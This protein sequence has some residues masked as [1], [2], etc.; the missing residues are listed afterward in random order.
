MTGRCE[1]RRV[2]GHFNAMAVCSQCRRDAT[3]TRMTRYCLAAIG[4]EPLCC[5]ECHARTDPLIR[6]VRKVLKLSFAALNASYMAGKDG[7]DF[8]DAT[9][10]NEH[11]RAFTTAARDLLK[12][13]GE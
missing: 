10:T 8:G 12:G 6:E 5:D 11:I 3:E 2:P 4:L 7:V 1:T 9:V 13:S